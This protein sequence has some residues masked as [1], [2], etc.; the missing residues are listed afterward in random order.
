[1]LSNEK[2]LIFKREVDYYNILTI[3]SGCVFQSLN[4]ILVVSEN[5]GIQQFFVNKTRIRSEEVILMKYDAI[6]VSDCERFIILVSNQNTF[7]F[8][9][10]LTLITNDCLGAV[11][12]GVNENEFRLIYSIGLDNFT[13]KSIEVPLKFLNRVYDGISSDKIKYQALSSL[14]LGVSIIKEMFKDNSFDPDRVS[15][16]ITPKTRKP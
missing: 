13:F 16:M 2:D 15:D 6:K 4:E 10:K 8:S 12:A 11:Y 7:F 3:K 14:N 5:L 1:M 9:S